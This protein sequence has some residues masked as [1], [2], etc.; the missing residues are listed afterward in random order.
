M[1]ATSFAGLV[2]ATAAL[3]QCDLQPTATGR[4]VPSLDETASCMCEWDPDGSGPL[5]PRL[6]VGGAF[7]LAGDLPAK[8]IAMFDPVTN[9]WSPLGTIDGQVNALAVLPN[10]QLVAGGLLT[11]IGAPSTPLRVWTGSTWSTAIAQPNA[12]AVQVLAVAPNGDLYASCIATFGMQVHRFAGG[13]WQLIGSA[14]PGFLQQFPT[15][16]C[17]AFAANGDLLA[18]GFFDAMDGV[19]AAAVARWNGSTWSPLGSGLVGRVHALS[20]NSAGGVFAGGLFATSLSAPNSNIAQWNGST[21]SPLGSG[22]QSSFSPFQAGVFALRE[23]AGDLVAGGQFDSAG[24]LPAFKVASWNGSTWSAIGGGIEQLGP[25]G[26]PSAVLALHRTSNGELFAAGGFATV[27]GRDGFGLARWN[28]GAWSPI[29]NAGI[30][31]ETSA[32]HR[33]ANGD[34]YLAGTFRDIDGVVCNGIAR[35]VGTTWQPLGSGLSVSVLD[36][37]PKV[38]AIRSLPNGSVVVGGTFA[39]IDGSPVPA[40]A[41]WD[42]SAWSAL[43]SGLAQVGGIVPAVAAL[44]V[45]AN[46]DLYVAG[47]FDSAGG[48]AV[49]SL[50]RWNGSQWSAVATGLGPASLTAVTTGPAG[51]VYIAGGFQ[52]GGG[53]QLG[54]I[55]VRSG[56][57]WQVIGSADGPVTELIALPGGTLLAAGS[58]QRID[59]QLVGCVARWAAG[60]WAPFGS[61]GTTGFADTVSRLLPLPSG[62]LLAAGVF[63][64]GTSVA[65]L[66]QWNGSSW[67]LSAEGTFEAKDVALD[68]SGEVLVAGSFRTIDG[69]ASAYFAR[70]VAPCAATAIAAGNGCSGS[71]GS[72]QLAAANAPWLG[73]TWTATASGMPNNGVAATLLGFGTANVPLASLL[74]QGGAGCALL[75]TPDVVGFTVPSGG[76]A[77]LALPLPLVPAFAGIPLHAQVV[78]FEFAA[79]GAILA[80]TSTNRLDLILGIF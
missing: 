13:S 80:V 72:N 41:A 39:S 14:G 69:V 64:T 18:G 50:A 3:A 68:P 29:R 23:V 66:A 71:G 51:E 2:L 56:S 7:T 59:G 57:G 43:G 76:L 70:V 53:F 35:R 11:D 24:G 44:H 49:D 26:G 27:R 63:N 1:N 32:V 65:A 37:G 15:I 25:S 58:F 77:Q 54:Q 45:A 42:G 17:L 9:L 52:V 79:A 47:D 16:D 33:A 38:R 61:L 48:V 67:T 73:A 60:T 78:P 36:F 75:V 31:R 20:T 55:A 5:G 30:G 10:G 46:G 12:F 22:T 34:V 6:V 8:G 28:G 62:G 4:G 19:A 74:P 21:W 40:L